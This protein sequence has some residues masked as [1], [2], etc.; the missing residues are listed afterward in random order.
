MDGFTRFLIENKWWW[1]TPI[2]LVVGLVGVLAL[3]DGADTSSADDAQP[4]S[5]DIR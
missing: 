5:Y 4:F 2:L 3:A 1:L